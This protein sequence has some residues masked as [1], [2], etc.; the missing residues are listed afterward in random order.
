LQQKKLIIQSCGNQEASGQ[1]ESKKSFGQVEEIRGVEEGSAEICAVHAFASCDQAI[2]APVNI[3]PKP[4]P[5]MVETAGNRVQT[6]AVREII[7]MANHNRQLSYGNRCGQRQDVCVMVEMT[8][9]EP[10]RYRVTV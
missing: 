6:N 4:S 9:T 10:L 7:T 3:V 2:A 1:P 5:A 8:D